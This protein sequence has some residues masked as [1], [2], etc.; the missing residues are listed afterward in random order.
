VGGCSPS[1]TRQSG[2]LWGVTSASGRGSVG[3]TPPPDE[4]VQSAT[5]LHV[6]EGQRQRLM[7]QSNRHTLCQVGL[8]AYPQVGTRHDSRLQG[9]RQALNQCPSVCGTP[10]PQNELSKTRHSRENCGS[11]TWPRPIVSTR[12]FIERNHYRSVGPPVLSGWLP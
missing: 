9:G 10:P 8:P 5:T 3:R 7:M 12:Y 11:S 1:Q 4:G 2:K 6:K